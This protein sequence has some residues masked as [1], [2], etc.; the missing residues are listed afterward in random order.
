M[1]TMQKAIKD[2]NRKHD[3]YNQ[4]Q[5]DKIN[6]RKGYYRIAIY[7]DWGFRTTYTFPSVSDFKEWALNV[8]FENEM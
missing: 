5:L 2:F 1:K 7:D 4:A 6:S 3:P 8:V